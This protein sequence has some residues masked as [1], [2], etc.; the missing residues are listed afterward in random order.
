MPDDPNLLKGLIASLTSELTSRDVLIAKLQHQLS[1]LRRHQFG[2]RSETIDQLELTIEEQEIARAAE[3]PA[4]AA[5]DTKA[6]KKKPKR[7]PLPEGLPRQES[8][9]LPGEACASCG[10]KLRELGR[11]VTEELEYI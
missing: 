5:S 6:E 4:P 9:L 8:I 3:A 2:A 11:D 7:R 1:G 10:G